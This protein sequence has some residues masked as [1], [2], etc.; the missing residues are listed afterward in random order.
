MGDFKK[1]WKFVGTEGQTW[2]LE[3]VTEDENV[4]IK[5]S[6]LRFFE[7]SAL[8]DKMEMRIPFFPFQRKFFRYLKVALS[9]LT[10]NSWG[11]I[12][13]LEVMM[14]ALGQACRLKVL[15]LLFVIFREPKANP[16]I[17]RQ[18]HMGLHYSTKYSLFKLVTVFVREFQILLLLRKGGRRGCKEGGGRVEQ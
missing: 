9:Q 11:F 14:K 7:Y 17:V 3:L 4:C 5:V 18:D 12:N 15:F 10:P 6:G 2:E 8:F 16:D 1:Y 13:T